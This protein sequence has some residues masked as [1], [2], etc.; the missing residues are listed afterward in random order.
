MFADVHGFGW[1]LFHKFFKRGVPLVRVKIQVAG[2]LAGFGVKPAFAIIYRHIQALPAIGVFKRVLLADR[3]LVIGVIRLQG[4]K[5]VQQP[6]RSAKGLD[7]GEGLGFK[8][9]KL[10]VGIALGVVSNTIENYKAKAG[11]QQ[12][13]SC[14]NQNG[15]EQ[16]S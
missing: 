13:G 1:I 10:P 3:Q 6:I 7:F 15:G 5:P 2:Y 16:G 11:Y 12:N 4:G 9:I 14:K 8:I